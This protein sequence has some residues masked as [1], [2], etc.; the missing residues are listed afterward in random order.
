[1]VAVGKTQKGLCL[2]QENKALAK[3]DKIAPVFVT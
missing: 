2:P 3:N 1:M